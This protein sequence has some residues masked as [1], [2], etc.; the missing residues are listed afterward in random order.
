MEIRMITE[1]DEVTVI[2]QDG[3]TNITHIIVNGRDL[4]EDREDCCADESSLPYDELELDSILDFASNAHME[5]LEPVET[6]LGMNEK[7]ACAALK[8]ISEPEPVK[9]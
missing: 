9:R 6:G 5:L 2:L 1:Q 3:Y 8:E 4:F 7:L